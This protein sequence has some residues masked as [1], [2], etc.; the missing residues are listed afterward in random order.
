MRIL[1]ATDGSSQARAAGVLLTSLNLS[2]KDRL[3][4]F[5]VDDRSGEIAY[6]QIFTS[7]FED[8]SGTA[9]TIDT[10]NAEGFADE[11]ILKEARRSASDLLVLG[12]KGSSVGRDA[13]RVLRHAPCSVLV[14]RQKYTSMRNI[15]FAFDGTGPSIA[16]AQNLLRFPLPPDARIHLVTVL[17]PMNPNLPQRE[18]EHLR[19]GLDADQVLGDLDRIKDNFRAAGRQALLHTLRGHPAAC[20]LDYAKTEEIDLIVLGFY[21]T[22]VPE[23]ILRFFIGSISE[24]VVRHASCSILLM[25]PTS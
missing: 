8:L 16:A 22:S 10:R 2:P 4:I 20:L 15:L 17:R 7:A 11:G 14:A 19:N 24:R 25:R 5:T 9:A 13:R 6:D 3:T 23:R 1:Y 18:S 21:N 12:A